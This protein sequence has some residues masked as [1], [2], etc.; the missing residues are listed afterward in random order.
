MKSSPRAASAR[1]IDK[2]YRAATAIARA[3]GKLMLRHFRKGI[4]FTFKGPQDFLTAADRQVERLVI[5]RLATA[6]PGDRFIGEEG[7]GRAGTRTWVIDPIDG[8][9]NFARGIPRFCISIAFLDGDEVAI[10][11][12]YD[13]VLDE[14]FAARAGKG[15]TVN[16][17]RMHVSGETSLKRATVELGWSTRRPAKV[18]AATLTRVLAAG[19]SF[20]RAGSGALGM[21]DVA[22]G[23][24]DGYFE[25]HINAWDVLAGLLM[26][27]EAGGWTNDF[28]ADDGLTRG[29]HILAC[30]PALRAPLQR[31]TRPALV[32]RN[33]ASRSIARK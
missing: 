23:R 4:R 3:A 9:A 19:A 11:V 5:R 16:G 22:A 24:S 33:R 1:E 12:I 20:R 15:A 29:N 17:R 18:Y 26:V 8:T 13:P 32:R 28:L 7:G 6:F 14:L 27:R 2:R 21:A 25:A 10:G 31:L 30:T